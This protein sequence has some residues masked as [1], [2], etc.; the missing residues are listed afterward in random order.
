MSPKICYGY[1]EARYL[2]DD[3]LTLDL[4]YKTL[5]TLQLVKEIICSM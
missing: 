2:T 3:T 4:S 1:N 5:S